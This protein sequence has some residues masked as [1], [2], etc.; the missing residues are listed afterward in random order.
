MTLLWTT[1]KVTDYSKRREFN[2]IMLTAED[3]AVKI[4]M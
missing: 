2:E 1:A 4:N 3:A